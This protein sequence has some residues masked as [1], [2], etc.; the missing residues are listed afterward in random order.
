MRKDIKLT[1]SFLSLLFFTIILLV[2]LGGYFAKKNSNIVIEKITIAQ[3]NL[4]VISQKIKEFYLYYG[5]LPESLQEERFLLFSD[6]IE[7][8][9]PF[10][11]KNKNY[12]YIKNNNSWKLY[13]VG[14]NQIDDKGVKQVDGR[15]L[16]IVVA[17]SVD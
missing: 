8:K 2:F 15:L 13:S 1:I 7:L 3:K 9:D 17:G 10:N 12:K 11:Y 16:D 4:Y 14:P 5:E 6:D